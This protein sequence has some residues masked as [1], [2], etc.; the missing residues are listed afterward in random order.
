MLQPDRRY[1]VVRE[2]TD[3]DGVLHPRGESWRF[4]TY[5]FLPYDDGLS[6]FV[7]L[8]DE[9]EWHVRLQDRPEQQ[10]GIVSN[11]ASYLAPLPGED[12]LLT[13]R[14]SDLGLGRFAFSATIGISAALLAALQQFFT[15]GSTP[16]IAAIV[17]AAGLVAAVVA[18]AAWPLRRERVARRLIEP[19]MSGREV[20]L[21]LGEPDEALELFPGPIATRWIYSPTTIIDRKPL[22][23][24]LAIDLDSSDRVMR[25][26]RIKTG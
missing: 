19:N 25:I 16:R 1:T 10:G 22:G 17:A 11:L 8:D 13:T 4:L 7:S 15:Q 23:I 5:S 3:F 21:L 6:L 9:S 26:Q 20:R 2:F 24:R 12:A 14:S 18:Y